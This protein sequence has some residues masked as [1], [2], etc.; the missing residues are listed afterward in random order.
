MVVD[1]TPE[2]GIFE[3]IEKRIWILG[4]GNYVE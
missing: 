4:P 1:G 2:N 3:E